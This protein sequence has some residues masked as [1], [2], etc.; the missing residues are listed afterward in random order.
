MA[1]YLVEDTTLDRIAAAVRSKGGTSA[2]YTVPNGLVSAIMSIPTTKV[3]QVSGE[4]NYVKITNSSN[5]TSVDI[6]NY[7]KDK[8]FTLAFTIYNGSQWLKRAIAPSLVDLPRHYSYTTTASS[9]GVGSIQEYWVV[10][11]VM[12]MD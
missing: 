2:K 7:V 4:L 12:T 1:K 9:S 11:E 6:S 8:N 5:A 10:Q 3:E